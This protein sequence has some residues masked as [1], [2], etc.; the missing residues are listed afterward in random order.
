MKEKALLVGIQT[1]SRDG[2]SMKNSLQ[3]LSLLAQTAGAL[4]CSNSFQKRKKID[5]AY[6]IGKGKVD[7]IKNICQA[8]RITT[9]IFDEELSPAQ[10]R[11]LESAIEKKVID[12]TNLI[13]DIFAKRAK[14]KEGKL[15]VELAQLNY[16]LPRLTGY[17]IR[18]SQQVGGIGTRGPGEKK[19]EVD[20]R[21]IRDRI[22]YL[23]REIDKVST[24][25]QQQRER[26]QEV[27]LSIIALVGYTNTGK[28]TL[29]NT[30][31]NARVFVEDKLF[32]TLDPTIRKVALPNKIKV[33]F[34]DTVGFIKKLPHQLVAAF[35]ATLEEVVKAD[36]LLHIVDAT[37]P[38]YEQHI[39]SVNSILKELDASYKPTI[40]VL[41][42]I[43]LLR[44]YSSIKKMQ[45]TYKDCMSIS[46]LNKIGIEDLLNKII[47]HFNKNLKKTDLVIPVQNEDI[48]NILYEKGTVL[49]KEYEDQ[50]IIV[51][52]LLDDKTQGQLRAF[53]KHIS[54]KKRRK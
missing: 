32:A 21:R 38:Q 25:R 46:A 18:L 48:L 16:F 17:G 53:K 14:T 1:D 10:Q 30:L 50:N 47:D 40:L 3:E 23:K 5:P 37:H 8:Q 15:Q 44:D 7:E 36:L 49:S 13:L 45:K 12:R 24:H 34:V 6:F 19:L 4:V 22:A 27:P 52:A 41:N 39:E 31:S 43:D 20:R 42:K 29:L 9:V 51:S 54:K 33:L 35:R 11:N 26:R 2:F 28:S